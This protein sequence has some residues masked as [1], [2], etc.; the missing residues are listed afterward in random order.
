MDQ[1]KAD[2]DKSILVSQEL[3]DELYQEDE[4]TEEAKA[5]NKQ[6]KWRQK[7]NRIA[8]AEGISTEEVEKR[9]KAEEAEK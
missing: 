2:Y 6:K 7:I 1:Y 4:K 3:L 8:K 9:L 5:K